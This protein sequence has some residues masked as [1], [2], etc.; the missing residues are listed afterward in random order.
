M[1]Y[2][3]I[4]I[5]SLSTLIAL[6]TFGLA[7]FSEAQPL[8]KAETIEFQGEEVWAVVASLDGDNGQAVPFMQEYMDDN[9]DAELQET[10]NL[11]FSQVY[12]AD[13]TKLESLMPGTVDLYLKREDKIQ[14][15]RYL[16]VIELDEGMYLNPR[17]HPILFTNAR[18]MVTKMIRKYRAEELESEID[19]LEDHQKT[20]EKKIRKNE[21]DLNSNV[22]DIIDNTAEIEA[23]EKDNA[24]MRLAN[25]AIRQANADNN[26][27]LDS[28]NMRLM[29]NKSLLRAIEQ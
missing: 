22:E 13:D 14:S 15:D 20:L 27:K 16:V 6:F 17:K 18:D 19:K 1:K 7:S 4:N 9:Y 26:A 5:F 10:V 28:V 3:H 21:K 8:T 11:P 24:S 23:M 2:N 29:E 12:M 25:D